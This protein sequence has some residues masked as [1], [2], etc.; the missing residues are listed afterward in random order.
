VQSK[1]VP[2]LTGYLGKGKKSGFMGGSVTWQRRFFKLDSRTKSLNYYEDSSINLLKPPL[3]SVRMTDIRAVLSISK[4]PCQFEIVTVDR[5]FLLKAD[6][7]A[8]AKNWADGLISSSPNCDSTITEKSAAGF[9]FLAASQ[10]EVQNDES[11][12]ADPYFESD[13]RKK[14][15][16]MGSLNNRF[17]SLNLR[18]NTLKIYHSRQEKK[19][20]TPILFSLVFYS[21]LSLTSRRQGSQG[22]NQF[23]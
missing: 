19:D 5:P 20:G 10:E 13:C 9:D 14:S 7:P 16:L 4:D 17:Y 15:N 22:H 23:D 11:V 18:T 2:A 8:E 12:E 3:G 6:S 21:S 1:A